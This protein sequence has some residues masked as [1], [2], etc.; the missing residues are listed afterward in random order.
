MR[1]IPQKVK[2]LLESDPFMKCC[3]LCGIDNKKTKIEWHHNLIYAG[4][5]SD[6]PETILPLCKTHHDQ[7]NNEEVRER[8]DLIMLKRMSVE[9]ISSISK[10]INWE[11]RKKFLEKKYEKIHR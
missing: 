11:H 2:E 9:Q 6:I 8:L 10:A 1:P 7:A 4:R 5:Q 3:C